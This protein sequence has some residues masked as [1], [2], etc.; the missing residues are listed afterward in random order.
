M[1]TLAQIYHRVYGRPGDPPPPEHY[2]EQLLNSRFLQDGYRAGY[3]DGLARAWA[4]LAAMYDRGVRGVGGDAVH[5]QNLVA[6]DP[7]QVV[8][9]RLLDQML[10]IAGRNKHPGQ[11]YVTPAAEAQLRHQCSVQGDDMFG[12]VQAPLRPPSFMGLPIEYDAK[13]TGVT[14]RNTP[15]S[16][17]CVRGHT[18]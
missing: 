1:K 15:R 6:P 14:E 8:R 2:A 16:I 18:S 5:V 3:E 10:E 9:C 12:T 4:A 13:F 11:L 7:G 17:P